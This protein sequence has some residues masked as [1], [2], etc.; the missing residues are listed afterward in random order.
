MKRVLPLVFGWLIT[1]TNLTVAY[2]QFIPLGPVGGGGYNANAHK[3]KGTG[4]IHCI[5]FHPNYPATNLI[6]AGSVYGGLWKSTDGGAN[7]TNVDA[8]QHLEVNSVND[9]E[10]SYINGQ[11]TIYIATGSNN[12]HYP[13]IPSCGIYKSNNLGNTFTSVGSFNTLNGGFTYSKQKLTTQIAAHPTNANILFVATSEGLYRTTNGGTTWQLVLTEN[14]PEPD[15]STSYDA[16]ETPGIWTVAFSPNNPNTVYASGLEV[17]QSLNGGAPGGFAPMPISDFNTN[18]PLSQTSGFPSVSLLTRNCN[19]KVVNNSG[20]DNIFCT[21]STIYSSTGSKNNFF[22]RVYYHNGQNWATCNTT[23]LLNQGFIYDV[24]AIDFCKLDCPLNNPNLLIT[25]R[26]EARVSTNKGNTWGDLT[27]YNNIAH[28][29]IR[30]LKF[31]PDGT[32]ALIGTDGGIYKYTVA[33]NTVTECN[34]GLSVSTCYDLSTSP[35]KKYHLAT[36]YQDNGFDWYN[37]TNWVQVPIGADGYPPAWWDLSDPNK[38]YC[39]LNYQLYEIDVANNSPSFVQTGCNPT[40]EQI[41]QHPLPQQHNTFVS[42]KNG[43]KKIYFSNNI[44][45][46]R[47]YDDFITVSDP[48]V[49]SVKNFNIP[50]SNPNALF[51]TT[52][53]GGFWNTALLRKYNLNN[54]SLSAYDYNC[55]NQIPCN[56]N[57]YQDYQYLCPALPVVK[58]NDCKNHYP[59]SSVAVSSSNPNKMWVSVSYNEKYMTLPQYTNFCNE[60][61][62]YRLLKTTDGGQNWYNDDAGLPQYP[63]ESVVYVDGSNDALFCCTQNGRVFYKNANLSSWVEVDANLPRTTVTKMEVNYCTNRL[64]IATY[65]RGVF[66]LDL[67]TYN[68]HSSQTLNITQNTTWG[69]SYYDIGGNIT[70]KSGNTLSI[71]GATVNMCK[72][73][74]ITVEPQAKLVV[75][76][77]KI[78]NSCGELWHGIEVWGNNTKRQVRI[79]SLEGGLTIGDQGVCIITSNSTIEYMNK[80]IVAGKNTGGS[81]YDLSFSGGQIIANA[82]Y[83]TNNVSSIVYA[84]FNPPADP[85]NPNGYSKTKVYNCNF[86]NITVGLYHH[87]GIW[88]VRGVSIEGNTFANS[89]STASYPQPNRGYGILALDAEFVAITSGLPPYKKNIFNNLTYGIN[90]QISSPMSYAPGS[91]VGTKINKADFNSNKYGIYMQ[92]TAFS[93]ITENSFT[94]PLLTTGDAKSYGIYVQGSTLYK[95]QE[96]TLN[97][98][99]L[100]ATALTYGILVNN[101]H[102]NSDIIRRNSAANVRYAMTAVGQNGT[103]STGGSGLQFRCN[104]LN[105]SRVFDIWVAENVVNGNTTNGSIRYYQGGNIQSNP[106]SPANNR[107]YEQSSTVPSLQLARNTLTSPFHYY[108]PTNTS[109]YNP[110]RIQLSPPIT[111]QNVNVSASDHDAICPTAIDPLDYQPAYKQEDEQ[112]Y[113]YQPATLAN[114]NAEIT[115]LGQSIDGGNKQAL[116]QDL[117]QAN[118]FSIE[119]VYANLIAKEAISEEVLNKAIDNQFAEYGLENLKALIIKNSGL[120][121]TVV[122]LLLTRQLPYTATDIS[123]ME[124]EQNKLSPE[125]QKL[126]A[127]SEKELAIEQTLLQWAYQYAANGQ[128][129]S[130]E[131]ML[132]VAQTESMKGYRLFAQM[133]WGQLNDAKNTAETLKQTGLKNYIVLLQELQA[134]GKNWK[135]AAPGQ[136]QELWNLYNVGGLGSCYAKAALALATDT[137]LEPYI[138]TEDL[139]SGKTE[140]PNK[141]RQMRTVNHATLSLNPNP[142]NTELTLSYVLEGNSALHISIADASGKTVYQTTTSGATVQ[143]AI[144]VAQWPNGIYMLRCKDSYGNLSY[145]KFTIQH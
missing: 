66:Y 84:K 92:G 116:K 34:Y 76:G 142:A 39:S 43:D 105:T 79:D 51:I 93:R 119:A 144:N 85:G 123:E 106:Q 59:V 3:Y 35:L 27:G 138:P 15:Y 134:S 49:H 23:G 132:Y 33:A 42:R 140:A 98:A 69:N 73:C 46:S 1:L 14:E 55:S 29:D 102:T 10:I 2:A 113:G 12:R 11:T 120:S 56:G 128:A 108:Y 60:T 86:D 129:D 80:G 130:A 61:Y 8:V 141:W 117:E 31:S 125:D 26:T 124:A 57:C 25:G 28:A 103:G 96:N 91:F 48:W 65:G 97:A 5:E 44:Q 38:F 145:S 99:G 95:I 4:Q 41:Y 115:A 52:F 50:K 47:Y 21:A 67:S 83:F 62:R 81:N 104:T 24:F 109:F 30:E 64:Y 32:F 100:S 127:I 122:D 131:A 90:I 112:Q 6:F 9:I 75:N 13:W 71:T 72:G 87:I 37:G 45:H 89:T 40:V 22:Y 136:I 74:R 94:I 16:T 58:F 63:I 18:A 101:N 82:S 126:A 7:W 110:A 19:I 17:Y 70:I 137:F 107:F 143:Q 36:G 20:T 78:T 135:E 53:V 133:Q 121:D 114:L 54:Y 77:S 139:W 68:P 118:A 88:G 111:K